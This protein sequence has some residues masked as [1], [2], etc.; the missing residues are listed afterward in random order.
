MGVERLRFC[1][2]SD[3]DTAGDHLMA[4]F[5]LSKVNR[6]AFESYE[7]V[8]QTGSRWNQLASWLKRLDSV[9]QAS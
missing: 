6:G 1:D 9:R 5:V 4:R 2:S 7:L 8:D 3:N